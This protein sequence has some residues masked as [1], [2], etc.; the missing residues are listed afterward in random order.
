MCCYCLKTKKCN[1]AHALKVD[2]MPLCCVFFFQCDYKSKNIETKKSNT[3]THTFIHSLTQYT[4]QNRTVS[5]QKMVKKNY[6]NL[7]RGSHT[8]HEHVHVF[9]SHEHF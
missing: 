6:I 7:S 8:P 3:Y 2:R 5:K 1:T 9:N 4:T